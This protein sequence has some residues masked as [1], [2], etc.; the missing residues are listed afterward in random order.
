MD[1]VKVYTF[2]HG[3]FDFTVLL[4][5][6]FCL[7]SISNESK[8]SITFEEFSRAIKQGFGQQAFTRTEYIVYSALILESNMLAT[9]NEDGNIRLNLRWG[10]AASEF[11]FFN[12]LITLL[13]L[14]ADGSFFSAI[15]SLDKQFKQ[16]LQETKAQDRSL[17]FPSKPE[18]GERSRCTLS[19][20]SKLLL[21]LQHQHQLQLQLQ[22]STLTTNLCSLYDKSTNPITID[23]VQFL[24]RIR[25]LGMD[26]IFPQ[27]V[28]DL[29]LINLST[30]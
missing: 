8:R 3:K 25:R 18:R 17:I 1:V 16:F 28:H 29:V 11:N 13:L 24:A 19:S 23:I 7:Q 9:M 14:K 12:N 22:P 26:I 27:P 5:A 6:F 2:R 10:E 15:D 21:H 20:Q 30:K 4:Q